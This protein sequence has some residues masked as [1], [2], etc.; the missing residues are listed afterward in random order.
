MNV[1]HPILFSG[2]MVRAILEGRKTQT[3]RVVKLPS[4]A[5]NISY[6][7]T[8]THR[9]QEGYADPG[10]N[11]WTPKGNQIDKCP[12]GFPSDIM[13]VRE[14]WRIVGWDWES[15]DWTI[16]YRAD[17]KDKTFE[18]CDKIDEEAAEN[19][20]IECT[21]A[22][23]DARIPIGEDYF[24]IFDDEH[25]CP[26]KWKPSIFMP[27]PFSRITLEIVSVRSEQLQSISEQDAIAEGAQCPGFPASLTNRDA[28]A[29]LWDSI[30]AKRGYSW[31]SNPFVWVVE[32]KRID[33]GVSL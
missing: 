27:R 29:K 10:V 33:K 30:N 28:F 3:R 16:E 9:P 7:D 6:W 22:C 5:K 21:N 4:D 17:G 23:S 20:A 25:P 19:Y 11:Y 8:P 32:F 24:Y 15:G 14:T 13:W 12:Y 2:E 26:T 18:S 31:Q 1:E